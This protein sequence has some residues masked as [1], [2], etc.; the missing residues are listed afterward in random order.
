MISIP[1]QI[2]WSRMQVK[3]KSQNGELV[4]G[5]LNRHRGDSIFDCYG[6]AIRSGDFY[7]FNWSEKVDTGSYGV[8]YAIEQN[9]ISLAPADECL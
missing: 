3:A 4:I 9:S 7:V 2:D 6:Y 1:M 5:W 8:N